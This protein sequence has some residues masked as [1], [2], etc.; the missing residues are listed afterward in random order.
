MASEGVEAS[1][2]I[3]LKPNLNWHPFLTKTEREWPTNPFPVFCQKRM[4]IQIVEGKPRPP[5]WPT[6]PSQHAK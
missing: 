6:N 3:G 5:R 2:I 1:S 4:P